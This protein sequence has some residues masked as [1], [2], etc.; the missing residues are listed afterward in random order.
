[1]GIKPAA[2]TLAACHH[3]EFMA[4]GA[5]EFAD[6]VIEF[7]RE[8]TLAHAGGIGLGDAEHIADGRRAKTGTR[9]S[10]TGNRIGRCNKRIGA[11]VI[12]KQRTLRAFK[13][14]TVA[15]LAA[16]V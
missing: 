2:A 14:D 10:L 6:L 12:V 4:L 15:R 8:R 9:S 1:H 3:A 16:F 13:Q 11:V 7:G 5:E